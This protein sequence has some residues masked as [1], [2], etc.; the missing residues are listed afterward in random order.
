MLKQG[1]LN[2]P[3]CTDCHGFH[4]VRAKSAFNTM[5]GIPCK[6]CHKD[7]FTAFAESVHGKARLNGNSAAPLCTSCHHAHDIKATALN[8]GIKDSCLGCHKTAIA[9]HKKWLPNAALHLDSVSCAVCHSPNAGGMVFLRLVDKKTGKPFTEEQVVKLLG[10]NYKEL[11]SPMNP[12]NHAITKEGLYAV[13]KR[14]NGRSENTKVTLIGS[15]SL[16]R[17]LE[18]HNLT[19]KQHAVKECEQ[20]HSAKSDFFRKVAVAIIK[21]SGKTELF[22]ADQEVLGSLFSVLPASQFY[23]LGSTRLKMLDIIGILMVAG[24]VS[25]PITH[26]LIRKVT[27]PIRKKREEEHK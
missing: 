9:L 1:N 25:F 3:V 19:L 17:G 6:N 26:L 2:A 11:I 13:V 23:A 27:A 22:N 20:C 18:A 12:L 4:A 5:A 7:V 24:G 15:I 10:E 21:D 8:E 16:S 14:L